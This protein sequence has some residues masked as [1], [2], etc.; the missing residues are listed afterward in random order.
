MLGVKCLCML[1]ESNSLEWRI[2]CLRIFIGY[3]F[4]WGMDYFSLLSLCI[5][6]FSFT[7]I[8]DGNGMNQLVED[9]GID[10]VG[11]KQM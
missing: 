8:E 6:V 7:S 4:S 1:S 11:L 2:S 5:H 3:L 10:G 9:I